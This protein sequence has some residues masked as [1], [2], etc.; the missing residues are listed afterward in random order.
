MKLLRIGDMYL[1]DMVLELLALGLQ[2]PVCLGEDRQVIVLEPLL[3]DGQALLK[4][5]VLSLS[6]QQ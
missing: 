5:F 1:L 2:K 4:E 3:L 6:L